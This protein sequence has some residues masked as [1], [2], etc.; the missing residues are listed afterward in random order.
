MRGLS[1]VFL[2]KYE[3]RVSCWK[4]KLERGTDGQYVDRRQSFAYE[5][6]RL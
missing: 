6:K 1:G 3:A 2:E 4:V 5:I